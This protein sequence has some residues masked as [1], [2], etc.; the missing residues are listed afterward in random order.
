M[1]VL[2]SSLSKT[3]GPLC[4]GVGPEMV[5]LISTYPPETY[6]RS[7]TSDDF[8][9]PSFSC[10]SLDSDALMSGVEGDSGDEGTDTYDAEAAREQAERVEGRRVDFEMPAVT[11]G[12]STG[13]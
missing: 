13:S 1:S 12:R 7:P 11:V 4:L 6:Q 3:D 8:P 2:A 10:A 5:S 9:S